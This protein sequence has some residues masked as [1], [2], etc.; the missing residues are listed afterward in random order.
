MFKVHMAQTF[1]QYFRDCIAKITYSHKI[2]SLVEFF[3]SVVP[4]RD[5][6][7]SIK[8]DID[9]IQMCNMIDRVPKEDDSSHANVKNIILDTIFVI[10]QG[11]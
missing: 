7:N 5:T 1:V 6:A 3:N 8:I 4:C 9:N 11:C 10:Q 2:I